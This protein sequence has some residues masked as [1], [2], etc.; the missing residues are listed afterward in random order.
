ME[1]K[2]AQGKGKE[3]GNEDSIREFEKGHDNSKAEGRIRESKT[4]AN[5]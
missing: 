1:G 5:D 3:F 2:S 4:R